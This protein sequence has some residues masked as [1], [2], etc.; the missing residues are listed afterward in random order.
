MLMLDS[1]IH[2][3]VH[4]LIHSLNIYLL[5]YFTGLLCQCCAKCWGR[6]ADMVPGPL[7]LIVWWGRTDI[8]QHRT[9][10]SFPL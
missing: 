7:K 4:S 6:R 10:N 3:F 8:K 2:S 5:T 1:F 9:N